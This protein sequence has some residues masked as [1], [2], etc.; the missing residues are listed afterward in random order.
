M[1]EK[2]PLKVIA[3]APDK[4][5]EIGDIKIPCY[6]LED[7][8]RVL[9]QRGMTSGIG[10][11]PNRGFRMPQF[12]SSRALKPYKNDDLTAALNAPIEFQPPGYA[13]VRL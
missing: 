7:K 4:P 5:L 1:S 2:K 9:S 8:T 13:D 12:L 10:L 3:G 6:V 11:D